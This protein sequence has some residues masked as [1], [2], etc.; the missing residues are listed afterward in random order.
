MKQPMHIT[1]AGRE[2]KEHTDYMVLQL[3]QAVLSEAFH[4]SI[5]RVFRHSQ[6]RELALCQGLQYIFE[7][8]QTKRI[9]QALHIVKAR[10]RRKEH[11]DHR[12]L[13]FLYDILCEAL[14][15]GI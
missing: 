12:V 10:R 6:F 4:D 1:K 13:Q 3:L 7:E 11:A 2:T 8:V 5:D 9:K 14:S 15:N